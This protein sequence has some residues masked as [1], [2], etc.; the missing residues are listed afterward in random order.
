MLQPLT[1]LITDFWVK[2]RTWP[3]A[4][5][6]TRRLKDRFH[7]DL[8]DSE[9]RSFNTRFLIFEGFHRLNGQSPWD[10]VIARNQLFQKL[11]C[12]EL[13]KFA[14]M[15]SLQGR[16]VTLF[17]YSYAAMELFRVAKS[18]GWKTVLGQI[19]PGP[20]EEQ[21]V[22][23]ELSRLGPSFSH[24]QPAPDS[25]WES[26]RHE[27]EL[28]DRIIV[29]SNWS[30]DCLVEMGTPQSK[31]EVV[32]LVFV[33]P[34]KNPKVSKK[35]SI[36]FTQERPLRVLF[37]GQINLRKG[38]ARLLDAMTLLERESVELTLAGPTDMDSELWRERSN[39][40][41][42]GPVPRSDVRAIYDAADV[43][44]LP[45]LSDGF[46]LT[47]LEALAYG[48]PV[49]ASRYCGDVVVHGQNGLLLDDL[50]PSTIAKTILQYSAKPIRL[51][52]DSYPRF[53]LKDLATALIGS[54]R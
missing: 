39:V 32:P 35:D 41:F 23:Q 5:K 19:D 38:V 52:G 1:C 54:D 15:P 34:D 7:Y 37:L 42:V 27:T 8:V 40:R 48:L 53:G 51:T 9:I 44:I 24:W 16:Q 47:Q 18:L 25:Y 50:E 11:A 14:R 20:R 17:S 33:P 31:L 46:A 12:R 49:I 29:N 13:L 2:P 26:W 45:T 4:F 43:F 28:A 36:A 3:A 30:K 10:R 22:Q 21:I 6:Q